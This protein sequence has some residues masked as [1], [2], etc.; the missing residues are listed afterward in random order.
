MKNVTGLDLVKLSCGAHGTLGVLTEVT[1]KLLPTAPAE[2]TLALDGLDD[3]SAIATLQAALASPF[4]VTGAAHLPAG[5]RG[6]EALTLLRLERSPES[7]DYRA[8]RLSAD[9]SSH[10]SV[11]RIEGAQSKA[12]WRDIAD[13]AP[14]AKAQ[15]PIVWRLSI[16][17]GL[18]AR[19][20][21]DIASA[22]GARHFYDWGGGLVW[23]ALLPREDAGAA[24]VRHA[25]AAAGGHATL[26]RAPDDIRRRIDVFPPLGAPLM[27]ITAGLKKSFDPDGLFNPARMYADM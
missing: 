24:V 27:K 21:A 6:P 16:P 4:E 23:L 13:V 9:L 18:A 11:R 20:V 26:M 8:G 3:A 25:T 19:A 10:G 22:L 12:L 15:A 14:F 7:L 17:A 1:F 5:V 2:T